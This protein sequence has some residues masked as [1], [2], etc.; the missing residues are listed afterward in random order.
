MAALLFILEEIRNKPISY[1]LPKGGI[2]LYGLYRARNEV[3][4]GSWVFPD[5][6]KVN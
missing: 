1:P 4:N 5:P 3:I 6:V 2:I